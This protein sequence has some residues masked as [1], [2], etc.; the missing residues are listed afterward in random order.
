[1]LFLLLFFSQANNV[2][3]DLV[4]LNG[5]VL[6]FLCLISEVASSTPGVGLVTLLTY[7]SLDKFD[8][9]LLN[10][11]LLSPFSY[12]PFSYSPLGYFRRSVILPLAIR[13]F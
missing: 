4:G 10:L 5:P 12:S 7:H 13:R 2:S 8:H 9:G 3:S 6:A 1:V 11:L